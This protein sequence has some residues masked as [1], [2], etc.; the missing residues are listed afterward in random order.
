MKKIAVIIT[1]ILLAVLFSELAIAVNPIA[2]FTYEPIAP[3]TNDIVYFNSTSYDPDGTIINWTWDFGDLSTEYG[4]FVTH[5]Y[6]EDGIYTVNLTVLD[7]ESA[8]DFVEQTVTVVQYSS[9][10]VLLNVTEQSEIYGDTVIFGEKSDASDGQDSFDVPKPDIPPAP[11]IYA[12]LDAGLSEPYNRLW[13][14]YRQYPDIIKIWD[15]YIE[16]NTT[17]PPLGTI[18]L[19]LSWNTT[20]TNMVEYDYIGLYESDILLADMKTVDTYMFTAEFDNVYH[21]QIKCFMNTAPVA[22]ND[23]YITGENTPLNILAPGVLEN[24]VD[25]DPLTAILI[26]SVSNGT[27]TLYIDGSFEYIPDLGFSGIDTFTYKAN[28]GRV[29]ST[30]AT[31]TITVFEYYHIPLQSNWNFISLPVSESINKTQIIIRNNSIDYTWDEAIIQHII[32]DVVYG[33]N[34]IT[35]NYVLESTSFK[36]GEGYWM[37]A[38]QNCELLVYS[39]DVGTGHITTFQQRWNLLGLP[40]DMFLPKENITVFYDGTEY[41]WVKATTDANPTGGPIILEFIYG[42]DNLRYVYSD[43]FYAGDGYWMYAYQSCALINQLI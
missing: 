17:I 24:D 8:T 39:D 38:Y 15:L 20:D 6:T 4:E 11:Y 18:N 7:N 29:N 21:F 13:E 34:R 32:L 26:T 22:Y 36:P 2:S 10:D 42:W 27:L 3:Y 37:W 30:E 1:V 35:Q 33:W 14:D 23:S 28:D 19:I 43:G 41:S 12:W 25:I 31:V 40:Y 5:S 16:C 9:W